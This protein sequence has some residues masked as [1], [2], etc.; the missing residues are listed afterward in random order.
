MILTISLV[1][2]NGTTR[3]FTRLVFLENKRES[4][5]DR[6]RNAQNPECIDVCQRGRLVL[7]GSIEHC[8]GL[9]LS[10]LRTESGLRQ[11][12]GQAVYDVEKCRIV[13]RY[14]AHENAL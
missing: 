2:A 9:N 12:V 11:F 14:V 5:H 6:G 1:F 3:G 8:M 10:I 7:C 4:K 13:R